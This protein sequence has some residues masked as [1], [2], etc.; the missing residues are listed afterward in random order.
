ML[1]EEIST[2]GP[3]H[4]YYPLQIKIHDFHGQDQLEVTIE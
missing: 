4:I 1:G 2:I 3:I